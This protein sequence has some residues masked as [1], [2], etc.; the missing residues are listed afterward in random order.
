VKVRPEVYIAQRE[1][2]AV[3]AWCAEFGLTPSSRG[4]LT[5]PRQEEEDDGILD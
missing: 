4:R 2:A 3:R 5:A 1:K